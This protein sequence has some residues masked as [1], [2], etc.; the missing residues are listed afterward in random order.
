[1]T[2]ATCVGA[3][4]S[5]SSVE[6]SGEGVCTRPGTRAYC[7]HVRKVSMLREPQLSFWWAPCLPDD[8]VARSRRLFDVSSRSTLLQSP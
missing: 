8:G 2:A 7:G 6:E 5:P 3:P 1:V 4:I